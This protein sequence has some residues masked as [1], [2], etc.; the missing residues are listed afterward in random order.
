MLDY[1]RVLNGV[2]LIASVHAAKA[3]VLVVASGAVMSCITAWMP[4]RIDRKPARRSRFKA[5]VLS[6]AITPAPLPR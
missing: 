2:E 1:P 5:A 3:S 4:A 6:V